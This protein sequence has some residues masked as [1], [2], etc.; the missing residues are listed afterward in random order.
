[1]IRK[2]K[3]GIS[4]LEF[5]LFQDFP[6]VIHALF[7]KH[8][9][10]SKLPYSSLNFSS[11]GGDSFKDVAENLNKALGILQIEQLV[12]SNLVHGVLVQKVEDKRWKGEA[13]GLSTDKQG[14]GLITTFADCQCAMFYDPVNHVVANIH[15]GWRGCVGGIYKNAVLHMNEVYGSDPLRLVV[16][17]GPSLGPSR[18]EFVHYMKEIP[19]IYH[20]HK[21]G[22]CHF[23]LWGIAREQLMEAGVRDDHIEIS[24]LCTYD[25]VEDFFSYR[26]EKVTGRHGG[27]IAL[28]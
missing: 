4:W 20:G 21:V 1:M 13:D 16:G 17:I 28:R 15:A 10:I 26:R 5:E 27:I 22:H 24:G 9:G 7:L 23:D 2:E 3:N 6:K 18:A 19:E 14:L 8:G 11:F 25:G 12:Q